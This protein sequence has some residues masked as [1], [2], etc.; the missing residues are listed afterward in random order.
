MKKLVL[1]L[2]ILAAAAS[3][4]G[5]IL[6]STSLCAF[7][8]N[9][10]RGSGKMVSRTLAVPNFRAIDASRAVTVIVTDTARQ[11]TVEADDNVIDFVT[12]ETDGGTLEVGIDKSV[13][14]LSNINVTVTVPANDRIAELDASSSAKILCRTALA[15]DKFSIEASSAAQIEAAVKAKSCSV[16]ASSASK[17]ELALKARSC[18]VKASS[19]SKVK[20][21]MEVTSCSIHLSSTAQADI[22]GKAEKC[23]AEL[24]SA[25]K[26][27][28]RDFEVADF[29]LDTSSAAKAEVCCTK[30]LR[31]NASSGSSISYS[32][33]CEAHTDK[34]S[35]GSVRKN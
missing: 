28:A 1:I 32:G 4:A 5:C 24:S 9:S 8:G 2:L 25:S 34:S 18:S 15:A 33:E 13:R 29:T 11:I 21:E 30:V 12:V 3:V 22:S 10:L 27:S 26:L 6:G 23:R 35:G 14:N 20:A 7:A 16:E 31:A 19:A 17:V